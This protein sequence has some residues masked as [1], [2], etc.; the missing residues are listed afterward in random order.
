MIGSAAF[1]GLYLAGHLM[2]MIG[3]TLLTDDIVQADWSQPSPP[4]HGIAPAAKGGPAAKVLPARSTLPSVRHS[5]SH[6]ASRL[7]E[8]A[9][10]LAF[11]AAV[12]PEST[13]LLFF[14]VPMPV[15]L[16]VTGLFLVS[17]MVSDLVAL[18]EAV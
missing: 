2:P 5:P 18:T 16:G 14:V 17:A 13:L 6:S 4:S 9:L 15:W 12:Y 8:I 1:L 11:W 7:A 3:E 10:L